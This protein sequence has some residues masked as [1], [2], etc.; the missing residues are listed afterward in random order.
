MHGFM[1]A[2]GVVVRRRF[3]G[4]AVRHEDG[5]ARRGVGRL[6]AAVFDPGRDG[7]KK[8]LG[9]GKAFVFGTRCRFCGQVFGQ[10]VALF[11]VENPVML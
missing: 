4:R 10:A 3:K 8:G 9:P 7:V 1:G 5:I 11:D 2:G 6:G